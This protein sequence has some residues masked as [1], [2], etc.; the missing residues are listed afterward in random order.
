MLV[1]TI[2]ILLRKE[3]ILVSLIYEYF[4]NNDCSGSE[5]YL[6]FGAESTVH[7]LTISARHFGNVVV[8][9]KAPSAIAYDLKDGYVYW[10]DALSEKIQRAQLHRKELVETLVDEAV[11][12]KGKKN[13]FV[14]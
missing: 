6:L 14:V 3:E 5:P 13:M 2:N 1:L 12:C 10:S 9:L 11:Q 7:N 8:N 4:H